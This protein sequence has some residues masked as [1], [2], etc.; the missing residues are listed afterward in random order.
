MEKILKV[1]CVNDYARYI[2]AKKRTDIAVS[3]LVVLSR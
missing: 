3:P 1:N 2:G